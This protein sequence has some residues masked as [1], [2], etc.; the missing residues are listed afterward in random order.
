MDWAPARPAAA[1][2]NMSKRIPFFMGD[3]PVIAYKI[4][5]FPEKTMSIGS[6]GCSG[7][8]L[9]LPLSAAGVINFFNLFRPRITIKA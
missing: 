6:D 5:H 1:I 3:P 4:E 2:K 8:D 9:P 7:A